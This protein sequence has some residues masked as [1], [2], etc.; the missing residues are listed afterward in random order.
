MRLQYWMYPPFSWIQD[1]G[2]LIDDDHT[3]LKRGILLVLTFWNMAWVTLNESCALHWHIKSFNCTLRIAS[4]VIYKAEEG[5]I[6]WYLLIMWSYVRFPA[7]ASWAFS[8]VKKYSKVSIDFGGGWAG[9]A[10]GNFFFLGWETWRMNHKLVNFRKK[11]KGNGNN[12]TLLFSLKGEKR[13][14]TNTIVMTHFNSI[15]FH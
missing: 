11:W 9:R 10:Q 7:L 14:Q 2:V 8:L 4:Q 5:N 15:L 13:G 3:P 1:Q 6:Q 12:V